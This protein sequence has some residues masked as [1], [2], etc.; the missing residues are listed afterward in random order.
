MYCNRGSLA[1]G[2]TVLQY[3]LK[4]SRFV[5]QYK[6]YCEP[7]WACVTIQHGLGSWSAQ[8]WALGRTGRWARS[9]RWARAGAGRAGGHAGRATGAAGAQARGRR[10]GHGCCDTAPVRTV[11]AAMRGLGAGWVSWAKLVHCAPGSVLTQFLDP[12]RLST[13]PESPNEHC[14]L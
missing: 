7:G 11:R 2:G 3:S 9:R 13:V 1:A 8:A 12:V 10:Y 6:L 5:L 4:G 14:S